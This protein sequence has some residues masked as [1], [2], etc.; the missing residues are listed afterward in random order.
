M[1]TICYE[2]S[3]TII[4]PS[5]EVPDKAPRTEFLLTKSSQ[6]TVTNPTCPILTLTITD[7]ADFF[8]REGTFNSDG[9]ADF[10]VAMNE[11]ANDIVGTYE[12]TIKADAEGGA[13]TDA[14]G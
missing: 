12:Y 10:T 7:G 6:F 1:N 13:T 2:Y 11:E 5:L 4:A 14:D 8:T 3:T 9:G